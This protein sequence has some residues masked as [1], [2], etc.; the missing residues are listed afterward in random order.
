MNCYEIEI[1]DLYAGELNYSWVR[2]CNIEAKSIRGAIQKLSRLVGDNH[3]F[4]AGDGDLAVYHS[5]TSAV[6]VTIKRLGE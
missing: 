5:V 4:V 6:G 1:T 2:K 3:R